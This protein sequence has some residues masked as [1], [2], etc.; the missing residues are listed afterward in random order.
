M[1]LVWSSAALDDFDQTIAFL[2]ERNPNAALRVADRIDR[3]ARKLARL[4]TGRPGRVAGTY[5]KIVT[6]LPYILAYAMT[7]PGAGNSVVILRVIHGARDWPS[8][9]WPR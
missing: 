4:P 3:A 8:G 9:R 7:P 1:R 6:G 2:A 5:E